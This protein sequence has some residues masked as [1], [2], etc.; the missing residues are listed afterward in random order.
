MKLETFQYSISNGWS[1]KKF[2]DL[3]SENTLVLMFVSSEFINNIAP[4][5]EIRENYP[6]SQ[7]IGCSSSGEISGTFLWDNSIS[8]AS[9]SDHDIV[10]S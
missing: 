10:V 6:K 4:I 5:L 1:E 3:D 7:I 9:I 8:L 2:P